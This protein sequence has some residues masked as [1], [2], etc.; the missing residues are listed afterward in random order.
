VFWNVKITIQNE[1]TF[2]DGLITESFPCI[3]YVTLI[4]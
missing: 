2:W 4:S 3:L 1:T